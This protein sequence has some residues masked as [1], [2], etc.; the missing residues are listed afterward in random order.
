M[1]FS[2]ATFIVP[3]VSTDKVIRFKT[4]DGQIV[5]GFNVCVFDSL[6]TAE[7]EMWVQFDGGEKIILLFTSSTEAATA[8]LNLRAVIDVLFVNCE[9]VVPGP[10]PIPTVVPRTKAQFDIDRLG[11]ALVPNTVYTVT[12]TLNAFT[13]PAPG[14]FIIIVDKADGSIFRGINTI[15]SSL[16]SLNFA[17]NKVASYHDTVNQNIIHGGVETFLTTGPVDHVFGLNSTIIADTC[18]KMMVMNSIVTVSNSVDVHIDSCTALTLNNVQRSRFHGVTGDQSAYAFMDCVIDSRV[19]KAGKPGI[20]TVSSINGEVIRPFINLATQLVPML[21]ASISKTLDTS[22]T[23]IR[24]EIVYQV[25]TAGLGVGKT[26]TIRDAS[27]TILLIISDKHKGSII[28]F[29]YNLTTNLFEL[30]EEPFVRVPSPVVVGINGQTSFISALSYVPS[31][32][33]KT[34][35]YVN[36]KEQIY[37]VDYTTSGTTLTWI[38]TDFNLET[39]DILTIKTYK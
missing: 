13:L 35:L 38:S 1:A 37:G 32:V 31:D 29:A 10:G 12:D 19:D 28:R 8:T 27:S 6:A 4:T 21:A 23:T 22:L 11:S 26:L 33:T 36:G 20:E 7:N 34:E 3:Y 24:H 39:T 18:S 25:P 30:Y 5:G 16:V 2:A 9:L 17:T 14:V 15:D